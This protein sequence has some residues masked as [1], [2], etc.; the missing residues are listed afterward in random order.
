MPILTVE[1]VLRPEETL[2]PTLA[3]EL[4]D[5]VGEIFGADAGELWVNVR[6]LETSQ[7]AENGRASAA[8]PAPVFVSILKGRWPAPEAMPA[9]VAALTAIVASL[10]DRPAENVH[11]LYEPPALGRIAFGG[12]LASG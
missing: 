8:T 1:I 6:A 4:A 12:E 9:E 10:C 3:Q 2:R 11:C 7:Y 5:Q